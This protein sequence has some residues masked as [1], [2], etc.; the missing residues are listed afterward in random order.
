MKGLVFVGFSLGVAL[1]AFSAV[2][3]DVIDVTVQGISDGVQDSKQRDWDEAIM[4]AKLKAIE[5]AGVSIEAVTTV[6]NF[7]LK[8]DW[9]ESRA[10]G[11]LLPGFQIV[12]VG[13]GADGLYHVVLVGKISTAAQGGV[14]DV[15]E[16]MVLIEGGTF[17]MGSNGGEDDEKPVHSVYVDRFYMD[18]Y[19]VTVAQFREFCK[20]EGREMPEQPSYSLSNHPVVNVRWNEASAYA[21]WAGKRLPTEAEWEYAARGGNRSS[22]Y[23]YS[24]SDNPEDVA[25]YSENSDGRTHPVGQKRPNELGLYDMSGNVW[26]W[27]SDWYDENY[28]SVSPQSNP[29]GPSS[30]SL[31]V[32]RG[33]SWY[34]LTRYC[35]V[36]VRY[37]DY[38]DGRRYFSGFRCA[39]NH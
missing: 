6:E 8:K 29:K 16:G 24:G 38:P 36:S 37:G 10:K 27:C 4:D 18:K 12:D 39:R 2:A 34:H 35:R 21:E 11:V 19:E 22:G 5:K 14:A 15:T 28:Y 30:G 13:Y 25:W 17:M 33:G 3:Q 26:E 20:A 32:L 1:L 7:V 23:R 31:R 9:I